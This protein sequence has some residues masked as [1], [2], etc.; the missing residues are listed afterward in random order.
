MAAAVGSA[1]CTVD[2]PTSRAGRTPG[3]PVPTSRPSRPATAADAAAELVLAGQAGALLTHGSR[4]SDRQQ[5]LLQLIRGT[6]LER[7]TALASPDP[8]TRPTAS[9]GPTPSPV[10]TPPA[11]SLAA[12]ADAERRAAAGYRRRALAGTGLDA[13]LWGSMSVAST[14]FGAGLDAA[15][16]PVVAT[17]ADHPPISL[18]SDTDAVSALVAAL[19]AAVY[20]YQLALGRL[21]VTSREHARAAAGLRE[22]R[23]LLNRLSD[24]LIAA[25]VDVPAAA[26]AYDPSPEVRD[27]ATAGR[28]IRRMESALLPF[29]GLWL[30]AATGG[31]DRR[32]AFDALATTAATAAS[33]GAPLIAWPGWQD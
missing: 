3:S 10:P 16:P 9:A 21:R 31:V 17:P 6:H 7:A 28:L 18:L 19:Q 14:R 15:R 29:C 4:L 5:A 11:T 26:P 2:D 25:G 13:L 8:A 20:G 1:G 22:R 32:Q 23:G 27:A 24:R 33:W 30:A 12:L